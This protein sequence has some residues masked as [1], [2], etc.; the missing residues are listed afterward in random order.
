MEISPS[1]VSEFH[2]TY[3]SGQFIINLLTWMFRPVWV[4]F[5]CFSLPFGV[6]HRWVGRY[7]LQ[8]LYWPILRI[9]HS[10]FATKITSGI[11]HIMDHVEVTLSQ[12][13]HI[14]RPPKLTCDFK[15]WVFQPSFCT[16]YLSLFGGVGLVFGI[17]SPRFDLLLAAKNT[18][19]WKPC[20]PANTTLHLQKYSYLHGYLPAWWEKEGQ[21]SLA[22]P[23]EK[24]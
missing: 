11:W 13:W 5:P 16:N 3:Y 22:L 24:G 23:W 14:S 10:M 12:T 1:K 17:P 18:Y 8:Q 2:P 19:S 21:M 9:I 6:T 20:L 7:K 4:G 15:R